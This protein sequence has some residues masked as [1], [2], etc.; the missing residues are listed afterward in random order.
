[1]ASLLA[2]LRTVGADE[3]A[4]KLLDRL[5]AVG[6]AEQAT[7]LTARLPAVGLF[8]LHPDYDSQP[9]LFD[10]EPSGRAALA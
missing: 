2:G 3:Q 1:M 9:C 6:A 10:R 8:E 5:R 4:A 7:E